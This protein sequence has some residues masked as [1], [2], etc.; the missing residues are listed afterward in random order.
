MS[1]EERFQLVMGAIDKQILEEVQM[2]MK[3]KK[4][5]LAKM[6]RVIVPLAACICVVVA[7][8]FAMQQK[9]QVTE[10]EL[11]V[12]GYDMR[13][14]QD[15]KEI[16]YSLIP[17]V[18][19][20]EVPMVQAEFQREGKEYLYRALKV[21]HEKDISGNESGWKEEWNWS[22]DGLNLQMRRAQDDSLYVSWYDPKEGMQCCLST[23][24]N[25]LSLMTTASRI[26]HELG[27]DV[28]VAPE[29]ATDITYDVIAMDD[30]TIAETTFILDGI[31]YV[32]RVAGAVWITDISGIDDGFKK[33]ETGMVGWCDVQL[34]Y[35]EGGVGKAL[36]YD[37]APG[38]MYSL[39]MDSEASAQQL[40]EMAEQLY[41]PAQQDVG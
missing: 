6:M 40:L 30:M 22:A 39:S 29:S 34:L 41:E 33:E 2:P 18:G 10:E 4:N 19:N 24:E 3:R 26:M 14:L 25:S 8:V 12:Y 20:E 7:I 28:A 32:Y 1:K 11:L 13:I 38:L 27:Y 36:W 21:D 23:C 31:R 16:H 17:V 37:F 5:Q 9:Q 35:T 15:A